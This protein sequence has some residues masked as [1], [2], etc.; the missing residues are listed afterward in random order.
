MVSLLHTTGAKLMS[1]IYAL[2]LAGQTFGRWTV[3]S[4]SHKGARGEIFW[5][6]RCECGS[7]KPVTAGNLRSGTS[8][9]CGCY[10]REVV[11]AHGMTKTRTWKS[12]DSML[13]R[14]ENPKAPDYPRYGGRGIKVAPEWHDFERFLTDVGERPAATSLERD[15]VHGDYRP[16]NCRWATASEQQRNKTNA[17][18]ATMNGITK[19]VHDWAAELSIPAAVIKWRLE[20]GWSDVLALTTPVRPKA[21]ARKVA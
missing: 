20:K 6:C 1:R 19:S 4:K 12:W 13:Q 15:D 16:G 21:P 7:E 8:T 9:S 17:I 11:T 18:R 10:H 2:S 14:C 3:I 5:L